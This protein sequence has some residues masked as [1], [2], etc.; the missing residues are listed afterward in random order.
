MKKF[1]LAFALLTVGCVGHVPIRVT[2]PDSGP[3]DGGGT[4]ADPA[5]S[6]FSLGGSV[7]YP[8]GQCYCYW[9]RPCPDSPNPYVTLAVVCSGYI[10]CDCKEER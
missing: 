4:S 9:S 7:S 5:E 3:L 8:D 10:P 1:V 6:I 2:H